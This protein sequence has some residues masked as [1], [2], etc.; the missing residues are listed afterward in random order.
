VRALGDLPSAGE[1][2]VRLTVVPTGP[3]VL[4]NAAVVT[5]AVIDLDLRHDQASART[6]GRAR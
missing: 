2:R 5:G 1:R 4:D 3:G 6:R